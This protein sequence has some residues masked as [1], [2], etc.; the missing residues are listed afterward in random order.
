VGS[1]LGQWA[2]GSGQWAVKKALLVILF[3]FFTKKTELNFLP[4]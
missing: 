1:G 4:N 2:V 3:A